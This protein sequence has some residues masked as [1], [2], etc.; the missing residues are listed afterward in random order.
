MLETSGF[1]LSIHRNAEKR[2]S[3]KLGFRYS[4]FSETE[5]GGHEKRAWVLIG[6]PA[7]LLGRFKGLG[8]LI[9][10]LL[11]KVKGVGEVERKLEPFFLPAG[12]PA[13]F[14]LWFSRRGKGFAIF[15]CRKQAGTKEE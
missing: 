6:A 8:K 11:S 15:A 4:R 9:Q 14:R 5:E 7:L 12:P 10:K 13:S 3:R 1:N 2:H